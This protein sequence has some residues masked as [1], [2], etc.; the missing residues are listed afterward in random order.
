MP[1]QLKEQSY[2]DQYQIKVSQYMARQQGS[3]R[4]TYCA[5]GLF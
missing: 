4:L 3:F 1:L 5:A 2:K